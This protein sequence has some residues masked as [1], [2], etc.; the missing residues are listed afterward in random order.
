MLS[1]TTATFDVRPGVYEDMPAETYFAIRAVSAS[2]LKRFILETPEDAKAL[3]DGIL[4]SDDACMRKGTAIHA[5]LLEP[6]SF[7]SRYAIG[8]EVNRNTKEWKAFAA[9]CES[10]NVEPMKPSEQVD[11]LTMR[12]RIWQQP[13]LASAL[14]ASDKRE[15]SIVW[16]DD[17]TGLL[18]KARIDLYSTRRRVLTDVKS[19]SDMMRFE[20]TAWDNGYHIQLAWYPRALRA[21][22]LLV[23]SIGIIAVEQGAPWKAAM[24]EPDEQWFMAGHSEIERAMPSLVE[25]MRSGVWPGVMKNNQPVALRVPAWANKGA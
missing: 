11:I 22:E 10:R 23:N 13:L 24:F 2:L 12:D 15:L 18:C 9:E 16:N 5:A 17:A 3:L 25:C 21:V 8:P 1:E 4:K 14:R 7:D 6:E 19:T 20:K